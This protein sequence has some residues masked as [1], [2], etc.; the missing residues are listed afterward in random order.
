MNNIDFNQGEYYNITSPIP[1]NCKELDGQGYKLDNILSKFVCHLFS[2]TVGDKITIKNIIFEIL[3]LACFS[4]SQTTAL[5]YMKQSSKGATF[6]NCDFRIK[7][8]YRSTFGDIFANYIDGNFGNYIT[9]R[10]CIFNIEI[11]TTVSAGGISFLY[12]D[13]GNGSTTKTGIYDS[14]ININIVNS[15]VNDGGNIDIIHNSSNSNLG[16]SFIIENTGIIIN[17][18]ISRDIICF[19]DNG[20]SL[21]V[22]NSYIVY[23]G[24]KNIIFHKSNFKSLCFYDSDKANGKIVMDNNSNYFIPLT[25]EQ[26]KDAAYLESIGFVVS[27]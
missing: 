26:C 27:T 2:I 9:F 17:N 15:N 10:Q 3:G 13:R 19:Y 23:N 21:K 1:I 25:T 5:F 20:V 22:Y 6:L 24:V 16:G 11:S 18:D 14:M 12:R 7:C 4:N 8:K